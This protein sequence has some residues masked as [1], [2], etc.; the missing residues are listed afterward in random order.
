[1]SYNIDSIIIVERTV[2]FGLT[3]EHFD[4]VANA[5]LEQD[6]ECP[7]MWSDHAELQRMLA[8]EALPWCGEWS[9][10]GFDAFVATVLPAFTGSAELVVCWEGGDS[11]SGL[12][13][14][15]EA[16]RA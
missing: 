10:H 7:E 12:R 3:L 14:R 9:G 6:V 2:D 15:E 8:L 16:I 5:L 13:L 4:A 11:Y 1:M